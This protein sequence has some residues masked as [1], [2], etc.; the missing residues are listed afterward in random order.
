MATIEQ[1]RDKKIIQ[2]ANRLCRKADKAQ[3][4]SRECRYYRKAEKL[5]NRVS[6]PGYSV[7]NLEV[8]T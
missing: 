8:K 4:V 5:F 6:V 3:S 2:Q 1:R 7:S